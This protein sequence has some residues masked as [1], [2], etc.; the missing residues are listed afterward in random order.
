MGERYETRG[1][2][3]QSIAHGLAHAGRAQ[4]VHEDVLHDKK[5]WL[6]AQACETAHRRS[7]CYLSQSNLIGHHVRAYHERA[8]GVRVVFRHC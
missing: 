8:R 5:K 4:G 2:S 7:G 1:L 6:P 3:A